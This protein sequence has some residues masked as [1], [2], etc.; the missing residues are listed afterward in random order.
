[1]PVTTH[2][3]FDVSVSE[4]SIKD[5][6]R[7]L[8]G[9]LQQ[10][11]FEEGKF[12]SYYMLPTKMCGTIKV[13]L[14]R[15]YPRTT[16]FIVTNSRALHYAEKAC[17]TQF[18]KVALRGLDFCPN[19]PFLWE[20]KCDVS[21]HVAALFIQELGSIAKNFSYELNRNGILLLFNIKDKMVIEIS[22]ECHID[23]QQLIKQ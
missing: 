18:E 7:I 13:N 23:P 4:L 19:V 15:K 14:F 3:Y 1:M 2:S 6:D 5:N 9:Q 22:V 11:G 20:S 10:S 12:R 21:H 17:K 8:D 16:R